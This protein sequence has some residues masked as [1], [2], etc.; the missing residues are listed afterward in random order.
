MYRHVTIFRV[1]TVGKAF[2]GWV[3]VVGNNLA[4]GPR[5]IHGN[6]LEWADLRG[7]QRCLRFSVVLLIRRM[8]VKSAS[9]RCQRLAL[10]PP[11]TKVHSMTLYPSS[12]RAY[13]STFPSCVSWLVDVPPRNP[14][15]RGKNEHRNGY[16][17]A[18]LVS[19]FSVRCIGKDPQQTL[20]LKKRLYIR[21]SPATRFHPVRSHFR[22]ADVTPPPFAMLYGP[23]P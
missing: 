11:T 14:P 18:S 8:S 20:S 5:C 17:C 3:L 12:L 9:D 4:W 13:L 1:H 21:A 10:S 23:E 15:R 2:S 6:A 22:M 19:W 16:V 7:I